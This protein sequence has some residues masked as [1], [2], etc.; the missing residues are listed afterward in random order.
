MEKPLQINIRKVFADKN[1]KLAGALPAF[2]FRFIEKVIHQEEMNEFLRTHGHKQGI[3]FLDEAIAQFNI[4]IVIEGTENLPANGRQLFAANHPLGGFDGLVILQALHKK[5]GSSKAMVNDL[6][7]N[8]SN[9]R[10]FFLPLNKHGSNS[11]LSAQLI[12]E[13]LASDVP[14]ITF[15][16]GIVARKVR[17]VITEPE[18]KKSFITKAIQ[19]RRDIVPIYCMARN[20]NQ[21]YNIAIARK[22]FFIKANL[23]MFLLPDEMFRQRNKT[24]VL[25]IGHPIKWQDLDNS[26]TPTQWAEEIKQ[27]VYSMA[28]PTIKKGIGM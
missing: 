11:R 2:I 28:S 25:R 12:D 19:S 20:S 24:I 26:K 23:E 18:W 3:E 4:N 14:I 16:S 1:P 21:F 7:M 9:L 17:G 8:I 15:P 13:A 5:Y 22:F 10:P 27:T 6:L